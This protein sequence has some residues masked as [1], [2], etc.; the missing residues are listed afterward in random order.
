MN[1]GDIFQ[2]F[3]VIIVILYTLG[4]PSSLTVCLSLS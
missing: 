3:S 2:E 4:V 1:Y